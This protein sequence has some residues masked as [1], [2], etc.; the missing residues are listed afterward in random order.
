MMGRRVVPSSADTAALMPAGM[1]ARM[2]RV[3]AAVAVLRE[4]ERRLER[5]GLE[6]AQTRCR[7]Q[8]RYWEFLA[9]VFEVADPAAPGAPGA[10]RPWAG[11]DP[12]APGS[13]AW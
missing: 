12:K 4:E 9:A 6:E 11:S 3:Q 5:L 7:E 1:G 13:E 10:D 8:R 2:D